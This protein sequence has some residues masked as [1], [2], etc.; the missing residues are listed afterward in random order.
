VHEFLSFNFPL[1]KYVFFLYFAPPKFSNRSVP[2]TMLGS[3]RN[4]DGDG[5]ENGKEAMV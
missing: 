4:Y 2:Y 1:C 3:L 5:N